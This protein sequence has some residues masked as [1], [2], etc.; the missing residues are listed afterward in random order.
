[1]SECHHLTY[2]MLQEWAVGCTYLPVYMACHLFVLESCTVHCN[3]AQLLCS[4][5][6]APTSLYMYVI[7]ATEE[8][9]TFRFVLMACK[10]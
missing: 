9:V 3:A 1:M 4:Q 5:L 8:D 2:K 7:H 6:F 10:D